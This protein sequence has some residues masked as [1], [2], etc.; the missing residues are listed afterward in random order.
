MFLKWIWRTPYTPPPHLCT[1]MKGV[2]S[3]NVVFFEKH[4][5]P[6]IDNVCQKNELISSIMSTLGRSGGI[7]ILETTYLSFLD[8]FWTV[9]SI[10]LKD[11]N[12]FI[13][14][15]FWITLIGPDAPFWLKC[16]N[17]RWLC[18]KTDRPKYLGPPGGCVR[19]INHNQFRLS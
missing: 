2:I 19:E 18:K 7:L 10:W 15:H 5:S 8:S 3:S 6:N 17:M 1:S 4:S 9:Q 13:L 11:R 12:K 14:W 16:S